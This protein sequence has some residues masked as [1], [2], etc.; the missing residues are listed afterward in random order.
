L[1]A[2][3]VHAVGALH[4]WREEP[5]DRGCDR[6]TEYNKQNVHAAAK[7]RRGPLDQPAASTA[8]I[9]FS[10]ESNRPTSMPCA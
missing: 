3:L 5:L 6:G 10:A 7:L 1:F 8:A 2:P 9:A 4:P